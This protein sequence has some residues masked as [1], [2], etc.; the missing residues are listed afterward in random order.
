MTTTRY[1][2]GR[3]PRKMKGQTSARIL[4]NQ[5]TDLLRGHGGTERFSRSL[6][7]AQ[8]GS[9]RTSAFPESLW[10]RTTEVLQQAKVEQEHGSASLRTHPRLPL[11]GM[12]AACD[13]GAHVRKK[14]DLHSIP[15]AG[16]R[17]RRRIPIAETAAR[18]RPP[19]L[20]VGKPVVT[21]TPV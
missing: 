21:R 12:V 13:N 4:E 18:A 1:F 8:G 2:L 11:P 6:E 17:P 14:R 3:D 9:S 16:F 20:L 15:G 7:V 10:R 19:C 5:P